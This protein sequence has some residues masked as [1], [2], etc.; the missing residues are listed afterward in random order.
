[1]YKHNTEL[2]FA[3]SLDESHDIVHKGE[4]TSCNEGFVSKG[5]EQYQEAGRTYGAYDLKERLEGQSPF[6]SS[7]LY[8]YHVIT[9]ALVIE[10][11][12]DKHA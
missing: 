2:E 6:M 7:R 1:M 10:I 5:T 12:G 4:G 9:S 8:P 3:Q 11:H